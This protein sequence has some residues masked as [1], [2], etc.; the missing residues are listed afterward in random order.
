MRYSTRDSTTQKIIIIFLSILFLFQP[1]TNSLSSLNQKLL[2]N[3]INLTINEN[4]LLII[5]P[6]K[7][8]GT[9]I[10]RLS[11]SKNNQDIENIVRTT[12]YIYNSFVGRDESE[13]I[14]YCIKHAFDELDISS[15]LLIGDF[16]D[17]P[18]RYC[19]N[20]DGFQSL[21]PYF[22]SDLYY[23]DLYDEQGFFSSWNADNDSL[24]GEW[25][26]QYAEDDEISL[27]PEVSVGRLPCSNR[28][29]LKTMIDKIIRYEKA[30]D[31]DEWFHRIVV[32]GGDTYSEARGYND[33]VFRF[34]EGEEQA[35]K[36][37]NVM[38]D[39]Q[40]TPLFASEAT[41]S[42]FSVFNSIW[43]GCGFLYLSG[44]GSPGLWC[45]H[46]PNSAEKVGNFPNLI[47]PLLRNKYKLPVC[48]VGACQISKFDVHPTR[49]FQ[50]AFL[51]GTWRPECWSWKLTS[52]PFGGAIATLGCTGLSWMGI[53][54][55]GGGSDWL[56]LEFFKEYANGTT[57]LG[58]I[59]KNVITRYVNEFPIDWDTPSGETSSLDA[60]TVQEWTLIG[61]PTLE[62][63]GRVK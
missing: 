54:F 47:I 32:A 37:M 29:E 1:I 20:N 33:S 34:Y 13:K 49:I 9:Q 59:W 61:D 25:N 3:D 51:Y 55:N 12:K 50:D 15:V 10:D 40:S 43:N 7:F 16:K 39:F 62:I 58:D 46:P 21:E 42:T 5:I 23:A 38:S 57:I 28:F 24:F 11:D 4:K 19:H 22:I 6:E 17:I 53:E 56:E 36:I 30:L 60:K 31:Y 14:K 8:V 52:S 63:G 2:Y 48:I 35:K 45:T 27:T 41:L 26:G 18:V 44:H